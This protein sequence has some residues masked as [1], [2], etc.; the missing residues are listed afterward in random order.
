MIDS[1][2]ST[3]VKCYAYLAGWAFL[4]GTSFGFSEEVVLVLSCSN[5]R[6][7]II[8][9]TLILTEKNILHIIFTSSF[10]I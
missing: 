9:Y 6:K 4:R 5:L 10:L 2:Y 8:V 1:I 7:K 3:E